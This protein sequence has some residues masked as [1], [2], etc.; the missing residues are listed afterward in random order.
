M[1]KKIHHSPHQINHWTAEL[2][3][4][5]SQISTLPIPLTREH[6]LTEAEVGNLLGVSTRTLNTYKKERILHY[7]KLK[8]QVYYLKL[9]LYLDLL[10][11]QQRGMKK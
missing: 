5:Q 1:K 6:L 3:R 8:G 9:F 2:E 10:S 4:I 7:I 11:H